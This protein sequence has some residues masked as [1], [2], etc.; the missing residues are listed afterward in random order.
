MTVFDPPI[1]RSARAARDMRRDGT[2]A[3]EYE[4]AAEADRRE[5]L[6]LLRKGADRLKGLGPAKSQSAKGIADDYMAVSE[7]ILEAFAAEPA[8][9]RYAAGGRSVGVRLV[10]R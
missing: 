5:R 7:A 8:R 9:R 6:T 1:R 3:I 2:V 4:Q 10:I